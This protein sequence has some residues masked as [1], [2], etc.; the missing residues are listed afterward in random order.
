MLI[1][2][3]KDSQHQNKQQQ[4]ALKH[5]LQQVIG[6]PM[7]AVAQGVDVVDLVEVTG[8][9]VEEEAAVG[10]EVVDA[11]LHHKQWRQFRM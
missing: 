3:R 7:S 4:Q 6:I 1:K 8:P 2:Q 9:V 10:F 5:Q 11:R